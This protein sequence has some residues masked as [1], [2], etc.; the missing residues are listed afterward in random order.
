MTANLA[1]V[2]VWAAPLAAQKYVLTPNSARIFFAWLASGTSRADTTVGS[3]NPADT[4]EEADAFDPDQLQNQIAW[5]EGT[6]FVWQ[7]IMYGLAISLGSL[8]LLAAMTRWVRLM[9][10]IAAGLIFLC[11]AATLVAMR[12]MI[13]PDYGGMDPLSIWSYVIVAGVQSAYGFILLIAFAR[14]RRG[15]ISPETR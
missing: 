1:A 2:I 8:A 13:H 3:S 4:D 5:V 7:K 11:T 9:H 10:L 12:L 6:V 14:P 15:Q